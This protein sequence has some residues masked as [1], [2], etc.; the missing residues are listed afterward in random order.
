[1]L[2]RDQHLV[3]AHVLPQGEETRPG[4]LAAQALV[5]GMFLPPLARVLPEPTVTHPSLSQAFTGSRT[6]LSRDNRVPLAE[7]VTAG[8]YLW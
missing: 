7:R 8:F 1:M 4:P 6:S 3:P 2:L 5:P